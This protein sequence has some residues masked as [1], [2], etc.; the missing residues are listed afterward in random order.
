MTKK[1]FLCFFLLVML[2]SCEKEIA[3]NQ[4]QFI[5]KW[6]NKTVDSREIFTNDAFVM[7][8]RDDGV[9]MYASGYTIN[10][11]DKAWMEGSGYSYYVNGNII[12][13]AG[14]S[15]LGSVFEIQL[16]IMELNEEEMIY[17]V[18]KMIIDDTSFEDS[19][20][21]VVK[22]VTSEDN[23]NKIIGLWQ[24]HCISSG[25]A[26]TE[27]HRWEYFVD[28]TYNY[29]I[30]DDGEWT[31]K[32]DNEGTYFVYG[33]LFASNWTNDYVSG[34]TGRNFECWDISIN[35]SGTFMQWSGYRLDGTTVVYEMEKIE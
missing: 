5:G 1:I 23:N 24:G 2:T 15:V 18:G 33:N 25:S 7:D 13:I 35:V 14:Q 28:G 8:F 32:Q 9:Q 19:S 11:N 12:Y 10:D 6:V 4:S 26:D 16:N 3:Q 29:Y 30:Y 20:V 34:T 17:T 31:T 22:K 27:D 21:Y